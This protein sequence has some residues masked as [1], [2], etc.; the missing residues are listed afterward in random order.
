MNR[1][2][3][4]ILLVTLPLSGFAADPIPFESQLQLEG[5]VAFTEGPAWHP[6]GNVYFSDI[7]NNRIMRRDVNGEIHVF[8]T[9]SGRTNGIVF[10]RQGRLLCCEGGGLDSNRRITRTELNGTI[11]VLADRHRGGKF[12]SPN[13]LAIDSKGRIYFTDP[14]YGDRSDMQQRDTDDRSIEGVYRIDEVGKVAR[15]ITHEVDRPNGILVSPND[16][17]LYVAD[18]VNDGP[19]ALG[20]NRKLWQF[21][22]NADGTIE[23]ASRKLLF[24][25]G[26]D[27]G[28]D[29]MAMDVEGRLYAAAGFNFPK[30]PIETANKHKAGIYVIAPKGGLLQFIPVPADMITNCTFGDTD[31]KTLYITAGHKLWSIRTSTPG[32]SVW[33]M[34]D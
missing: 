21:D 24:D 18:N 6:D 32:V 34:N 31:R 33:P 27:R 19:N 30:P 15:I 3:I 25:W 10:D 12:N 28:P 13:D 23:P 7:A 14:R 22:L 9:P 29:G 5:R 26:T 8:R 20:G 2:F 11:T 16:K 4:L 1:S 17:Y